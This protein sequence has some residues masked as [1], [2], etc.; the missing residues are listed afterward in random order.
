MIN[1]RLN[2]AKKVPQILIEKLYDADAAQ[3]KDDKLI[4]EAG[5]GLYAR[6]MSIITVTEAYEN[7]ILTCPE[8]EN[9][10]AYDIDLKEFKCNCGLIISWE[11]FKKSYKNKQ[12]YGANALPVFVKFV[13]NFPRCKTYEQKMIAIDT[14]INSFHI[15]HSYRNNSFTETPDESDI[16]GRPTGANLIEGTLHEVIDFLNYLS[17]K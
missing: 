7:K 5:W 13:D 14:L 9:K 6:C 10:M 11:D 2:W 4:D 17:N 16:L 1:Y 12:L 15:L 3:L 8:C